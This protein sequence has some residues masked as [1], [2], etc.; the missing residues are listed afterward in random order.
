MS[1]I[2]Q[3]PRFPAHKGPTVPAPSVAR[4]V[5]RL[6]SPRG[7]RARLSTF[8]FHRVQPHSD[9]LFPGE[10]DAE[11]FE[12]T[13]Q[14]VRS[15]FNVLPAQEA[16]SRLRAGTLPERALC[17]TFDDGYA[18]N[19]SVA[20]P[21]L[22]R[23]SLPATFFIATGFLDGGRMWN[24]SIIEA[25]RRCRADR[26]DLSEM[27]LGVHSLSSVVE[28]RAAI[29][30]L[31]PQLKYCIPEERERRVAAVVARS[32]SSMPTKLMMTSDD[33]RLLQR[34]GMTIGAH[35][36]NHPILTR[37]DCADAKEDIRLGAERL[38]AITGQRVALF[39]YPN[40]QPGNDY[41]HEHV[42]LVKELGFAGAF[43][44]AWG[45][46]RI[47]TDPFQIPRFTPW[48][49]TASKFAVRLAQNLLRTPAHAAEPAQA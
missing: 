22:S 11:A 33:V 44:T 49:G 48:G 43:S 23:L 14:W 12:R 13:M 2:G 27:D 47:D 37:I 15:W 40:G 21:I 30:T 42:A 28:R 1:K 31:L 41:R 25:I 29:A 38:E 6:L 36:H 32:G 9:P 8:I 35:T 3:M 7:P 45:T 19:A 5:F 16:L 34:S 20:L 4:K 10:P 26:L 39:A 17:I 46:A 18:D 24:D